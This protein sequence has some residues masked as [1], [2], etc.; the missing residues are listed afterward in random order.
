M[1]RNRKDKLGA[2]PRSEAPGT[3]VPDA[4]LEPTVPP[5]WPEGLDPS[6]S[7]VVSDSPRRALD[8]RR[9]GNPRK[10][11]LHAQPPNSDSVTDDLP[12][13]PSKE[14]AVRDADVE[15]DATDP[16]VSQ[17]IARGHGDSQSV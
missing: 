4:F 6:E 10:E 11:E 15:P 9:F 14:R 8:P 12:M 16:G 3:N 5:E 1:P 7:P 13:E 2:D 17:E